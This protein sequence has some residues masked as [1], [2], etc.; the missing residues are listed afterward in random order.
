[1]TSQELAIREETSKAVATFRAPEFLE[2]VKYALPENE[3]PHKFVRT[4]VTALME[5]NDLVLADR[6]SLLTA[7]FKSA[8]MGLLPDGRE[9]VINVY[10]TKLKVG[11]QDTWIQKAT[12]IPM[13]DGYIKIVGEY[14]WSLI[15]DVIYANDD[16][17]E[18]STEKPLLHRRAKLGTDR[19]E[20]IGA[21]ALATHPSKGFRQ[22]IY[23]KAE[24]EKVRTTSKQ[25]QGELWT[26][27]W[28]RAWKK[29]VAKYVAKHLPLDAAD[30]EQL[31]RRLDAEDLNGQQ[32][33]DLL[34]GPEDRQAG[35]GISSSRARAAEPAGEGMGSPVSSS[36][37]VYEPIP[38]EADIYDPTVDEEPVP[39][40]AGP[41]EPDV[42]PAQEA[43]PVQAAAA[44]ANPE[45]T[46]A[47]GKHA[48]IPL[49]DILALGEEGRAYL[50]WA[51][52]SW[53]DQ[54]LRGALD[55]FAKA[56]PEI[57]KKSA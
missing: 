55:E 41:P 33:T 38:D 53:K 22:A 54:P 56:H 12:L 11:G 43:P 6:N 45:A 31:V 49:G 46:F 32:A 40:D 42:A 29:T 34:Y 30:K 27:W 9:A 5:R 20:P 35:E 44:N 37:P 17:D 21:F 8:Q 4:L 47:V 1:M 52:K 19:G 13:V 48:G 23:D 51:Y 10:N 14:G 7:A 2:Q 15:A 18:G 57:T 50:N 28:D 3:S 36:E 25:P 26:K 16:F 24:I 39:E